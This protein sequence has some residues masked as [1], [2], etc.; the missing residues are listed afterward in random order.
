M[1]LFHIAPVEP[2]A[3]SGTCGFRCSST[4]NRDVGSLVYDRDEVFADI[5]VLYAQASSKFMRVMSVGLL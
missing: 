1:C 3:E 5:G 4:C 2:R